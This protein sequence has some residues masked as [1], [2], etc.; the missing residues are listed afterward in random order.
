MNWEAAS[1]FLGAVVNVLSYAYFSGRLS[2]SVRD[3]DKRVERIEQILDS[4][5]K[6]VLQRAA[7]A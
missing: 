4:A 6:T 2:Q 3:L 7:G 5:N 1:F